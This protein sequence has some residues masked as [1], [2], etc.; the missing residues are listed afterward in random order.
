LGVSAAAVA[1]AI[2]AIAVAVAVAAAV[3]AVAAK[4]DAADEGVYSSSDLEHYYSWSWFV[5][6]C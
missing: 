2:A 5:F 4:F 1:A 3:Y 6:E